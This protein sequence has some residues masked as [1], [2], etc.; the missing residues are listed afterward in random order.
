[1][2]VHLFFPRVDPSSL[3]RQATHAFGAMV[4]KYS[5]QTSSLLASLPQIPQVNNHDLRSIVPVNCE[6]LVRA[7]K[8]EDAARAEEEGAHA[9]SHHGQDAR[10]TWQVEPSF[11]RSG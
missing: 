3:K 7:H 5:H 6:R 10:D 1:M 4:S 2:T 8:V 11:L 9:G